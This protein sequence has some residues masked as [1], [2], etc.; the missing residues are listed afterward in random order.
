MGEAESPGSA[1]K[2]TMT[3]DPSLPAGFLRIS[4]GDAK[5]E[6]M[7]VLSRHGL[8]PDRADQCARVFVDN[9]IDG[10][11]SHGINRFA[12]FIQYITAGYIRV[13][14]LPVL[15]HRAGGIEQW[16]GKL[17]P[18][19]LNALFATERALELSKEHGVGCVA[20]AN[21][22]HWMR[23]GYY[24]WKAAKAGGV[25]IG[26]S[27]TLPN[28]PAWGATDCR[29]GNNP[30]VLAV[31]YPPEA[32]VLDMAMSQ[33]SYGSLETHKLEARQLPLPGG[34]DRN[35]RQTRDPAEILATQRVMP[36]G[37]WKGSG[38]ALLLD[39]LAT[40]LSGGL[41]TFRIGKNGTDHALSQVFITIDISR[42]G[43]SSAVPAAIDEIIKDYKSSIPDAGSPGVIYP[44]ERV[45]RVR[46]ENAEK[47]IPVSR[48][49]WEEIMSL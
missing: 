31:P 30:I 11:Y 32:I 5:K 33:F 42:L 18:G 4:S 14:G 45:L 10:I 15:K 12:R 23:G 48:A 16:D 27:N 34:Y 24:G 29:L 1:G 39:L 37:Y 49:I 40:V 38:M 36:A 6:F 44:G 17:G 19:P 41:S 2:S 35:G 7:R 47:G 3:D 25:F 13:H 46:K 22:N 9:S 8:A 20:L 26:W 28:M 21:T 43:N